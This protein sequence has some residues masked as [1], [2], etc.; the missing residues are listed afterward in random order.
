MIKVHRSVICRN[1]DFFVNRMNPDWAPRSEDSDVIILAD[2]GIE[3]VKEY[4]H[5]L[6]SGEV[7]RDLE[8]RKASSCVNNL[9]HSLPVGF[10]GSPLNQPAQDVGNTAEKAYVALAGANIFGEK[11]LDTRYRNA[12]VETFVLVKTTFK[13]N[14]GPNCVRVV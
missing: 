11:Y 10:R 7:V 2:D 13:W 9:Q 14:A 4:V 6:Y 12:L 1:S 5:W 8:S 3:L